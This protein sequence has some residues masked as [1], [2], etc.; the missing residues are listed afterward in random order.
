MQHKTN[1]LVAKPVKKVGSSLEAVLE[2]QDVPVSDSADQVPA[3][4]EE[5]SARNPADT[6]GLVSQ[7]L[8]SKVV[9]EQLTADDGFLFPLSS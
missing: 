7:H 9:T 6:D 1:G 2:E 5:S 3:R 4:Q 8:C